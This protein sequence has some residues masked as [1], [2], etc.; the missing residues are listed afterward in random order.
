MDWYLKV[1]FLV[2]IKKSLDI[3]PG[4]W[5]K[6]NLANILLMTAPEYV[7][8]WCKHEEMDNLY[9]TFLNENWFFLKYNQRLLRVSVFSFNRKVI[10][11]KKSL[12]K[13][14]H[15]TEPISWCLPENGPLSELPL[16]LLRTPHYHSSRK[17]RPF[18]I[19]GMPYIYYIIIHLGSQEV[20]FLLSKVNFL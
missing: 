13:K 19:F 2:S 15:G 18:F 4:P 14:S 3:G 1:H 6:Q 8:F 10:V 7:V 17:S 16:Y 12:R 11:K 20:L 5:L 9:S